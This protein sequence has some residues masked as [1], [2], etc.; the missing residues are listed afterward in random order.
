MKRTQC[1]LRRRWDGFS[2]VEL[3]VVIAI[4]STLI[5]LLLPAVQR[6]R[7][8]A[9]RMSCANN[10]HQLGLAVHNY[11]GVYGCLPSGS[12]GPMNT[13]GTFPY[14]W[15]DPIYG[16]NYPWGHFGWPVPL[17]PFLEQANLYQQI[18]LNVAAYA[19][20]VPFNDGSERGPAGNLA[21]KAP[22]NN[23]PA[24]LSCP[25]AH[26]VKPNNQFKD[27]A[28]NYGSG[29][30][31]IFKLDGP[32]RAPG[33]FDGIGWV[34]SQVRFSDIVDGLSSTILFIESAHFSSHNGV[35]ADVGSNQFFWVDLNSTGYAAACD[36]DGTPAP[37]NSTTFSNRGAHSD[38][39]RGVQAVMVDGHVAWLPNSIDF[40]V[41]QAL[42]TRAGGE[43]VPSF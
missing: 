4:I 18:N 31:Q 5:G 9:K 16:T 27:Y 20:S 1:R 34:N 12:R 15:Y 2:L 37:P 6:V 26:R 32:E 11:E 24:V 35:P 38:H 41:Y 30:N 3:L 8:A 29:V 21:N 33:G 7:E 22:A 17:L 13:D 10:L 43:V 19:E 39:P 14:G 42:F 25:S 40:T 23:M 28:I 36:P